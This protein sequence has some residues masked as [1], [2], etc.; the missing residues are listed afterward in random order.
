ME[1]AAQ[2]TQI[3]EHQQAWSCTTVSQKLPGILKAHTSYLRASLNHSLGQLWGG[4]K[5]MG[6]LTLEDALWQSTI[7]MTIVLST[8]LPGN[9]KNQMQ[10]EEVEGVQS[11]LLVAIGKPCFTTVKRHA[12]H[13]GHIN[14]DL[15]LGPEGPVVPHAGTRISYGRP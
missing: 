9:A 5:S 10:A 12:Q 4:A 3:G 13:A 1:E 8:V 11:L 15:Q 6:Q 2:L 7:M 14:V